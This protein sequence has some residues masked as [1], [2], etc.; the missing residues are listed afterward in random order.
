MN[1]KSLRW[2]VTGFTVIY[3]WIVLLAKC[4][5][6]FPTSNSD[7]IYVRKILEKPGETEEENEMVESFN[8]NNKP[9]TDLKSGVGCSFKNHSFENL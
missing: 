4:R 9:V 8:N 7:K 6:L 2:L 5:V 1:R 3:L